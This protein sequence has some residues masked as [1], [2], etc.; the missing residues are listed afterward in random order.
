MVPELLCQ[1]PIQSS[2]NE[3]W[4]ARARR[5]ASKQATARAVP[6]ARPRDAAQREAR[7][8]PTQSDATTGSRPCGPRGRGVGRRAW[9][10]CPGFRR[11]HSRLDA[12]WRCCWARGGREGQP[13]SHCGMWFGRESNRLRYRELSLQKWEW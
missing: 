2:H 9:T 4:D 6:R 7:N 8:K 5:C 1:I 13:L 11:A 12:V 10:P 3:T